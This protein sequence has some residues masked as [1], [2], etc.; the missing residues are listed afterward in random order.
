M[1]SGAVNAD[2][3]AIV[4]LRVIGPRGDAI[5]VD[6]VLDTE[7]SGAL[8]LPSKYIRQLKLEWYHET[9]AILADGSTVAFDVFD[10]AVEWHGTIVAVKIDAAEGD[11]MIGMEL[12]QGHRVTL[13]IIAGG[14]VTIAP[15][16]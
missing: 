3:D 16:P 13:D 2:I 11:P 15:L 5:L 14:R 4:R 1:I 7:F 12:M 9:A 10:G 6:F 8:S